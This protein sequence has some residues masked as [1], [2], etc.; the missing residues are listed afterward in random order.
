[1]SLQDNRLYIYGLLP[2]A[3]LIMLVIF[4]P[5]G[6]LFGIMNI[7]FIYKHREPQRLALEA[8]QREERELKFQQQL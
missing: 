4:L 2:L 7:Y 6:L 3:T 5:F 1:M 8:K